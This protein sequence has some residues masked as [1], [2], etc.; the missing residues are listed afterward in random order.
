MLEPLF[1]T[2][3]CGVWDRHRIIGQKNP[4]TNTSNSFQRTF[5]LSNNHCNICAL[6]EALQFFLCLLVFTM[7]PLVTPA[8][9]IDRAAAWSVLCDI[10]GT[11]AYFLSAD[12]LQRGMMTC[13]NGFDKFMDLTRCRGTIVAKAVPSARMYFCLSTLHDR[14]IEAIKIKDENLNIF[15]AGWK[16]KNTISSCL[17]FRPVSRMLES[18]MNELMKSYASCSS[19]GPPPMA[20]GWYIKIQLGCSP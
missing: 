11:L 9:W 16:T 15:T 12:I 19:L 20:T 14:E 17:S 8:A 3:S 4:K 2:I 13:I 18:G 5:L 7:S 6:C 1:Q 10:L